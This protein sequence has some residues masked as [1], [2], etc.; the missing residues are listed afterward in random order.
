M[1]TKIKRNRT[2]EIKKIIKKLTLSDYEYIAD[3][4]KITLSAMA[5]HLIDFLKVVGIKELLETQVHLDKRKSTYSPSCLSQLLTLHTIL[6]YDRIEGSRTLNLDDHYKEKLQ[7]K[8]YPD[9]ETLRDELRRYSLENIGELF[10]V[11]QKLLELLTKQ[12]TPQ[13]I[14]LPMDAKVVT[15]YGDQEKA[16]KGYNPQKPGR[17]S[18][19]LKLCTV[20]PFG[21]ILALRVEPG[22]AVSST[23]FETFYRQCVEAIPT[24]HFVVRTI[25]LDRGFFSEDNIKLF[26]ADSI[27]FEVVAKQYQSLKEFVYS[28]PEEAFEPFDSAETIEGASF[29]FSLNS[30]EGQRDFVVVRKRIRT[31]NNGQLLLFDHLYK[32]HYQV[33]CHN[34]MDMTPYE[35]WK[36]YNQRAR[37]E[38]VVKELDYDYFLTKVPTEHYLANCAYFWH[39]VIA[40][41]IMLIFKRYLLQ[42]EWMNK[43]ISTLRKKLFSIPGIVVNRSGTMVMRMIKGFKEVALFNSLTPKLITFY[44]RLHAPPT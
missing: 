10:I 31:E 7:I 16:E 34:T 24:T 25:R 33:I 19:H 44:Q 29:R 6:G 3:D 23:G 1:A 12:E 21:F 13:Y 15:V 32:W 30:W 22:D 40:S 35:V 5:P 36:D 4:E 43:T 11:N 9:P 18:Y 14:D 2:K 28:I 38:L 27:F 42:G 17:K 20:E 26:E 41:N 8:D 39:S 37:I